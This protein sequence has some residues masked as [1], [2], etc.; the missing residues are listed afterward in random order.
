MRRKTRI[1]FW[2]AH[3]FQ[4][5][6]SA[7]ANGNQL[8]TKN[9][10]LFGYVLIYEKTEYRLVYRTAAFADPIMSQIDKG[11]RKEKDIFL[12]FFVFFQILD[13]GSWFVVY[14]KIYYRM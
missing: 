11:E 4:H 13:F 14:E 10:V 1:F 2:C 7:P 5:I 6:N 3:I 8:H 12:F 9:M